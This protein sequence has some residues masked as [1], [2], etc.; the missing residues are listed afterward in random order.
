MLVLRDIRQLEAK[1]VSCE[2]RV[3]RLRDELSD[4]ASDLGEL[5]ALLGRLT[6]EDEDDDVRTLLRAHQMELMR[7]LSAVTQSAV[8]SM[9]GQAQPQLQF[10]FFL[11]PLKREVRIGRRRISFTP[12]EFQVVELLW[13]QMPSPVSRAAMLER[14]YGAAGSRSERVIDVHM[15]NIRQ[16]LSL[17]GAT[18]VT[19]RAMTGRGWRLDLKL[20]DGMSFEDATRGDLA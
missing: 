19:V 15:Y 18:D 17:A 20:A 11:D 5:G 2:A 14:L 12:R 9:H 10:P 3:A 16:K 7:A 6:V 8:P 1:F 13:E 4:L